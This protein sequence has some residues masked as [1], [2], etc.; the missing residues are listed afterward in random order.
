[1][2]LDF[3]PALDAA[4]TTNDSAVFTVYVPNK[5]ILSSVLLPHYI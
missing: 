1:M 4:T 2:Y 3:V 5:W